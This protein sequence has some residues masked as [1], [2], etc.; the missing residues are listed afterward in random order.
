ME[1]IDL[2]AQYDTIKDKVN[3]RIQTV[4]DHRKFILGP[5]VEE[6]EKDM[7]K[8]LGVK[9]A[10]GVANGTD[11]LLICL[12]A[13]DVRQGDKVVVPAFTFFAT[14]EVVSML[15]AEPVFCDVDP[16]TY[17]LDPKALEKIISSKIKAIMPVSLYG[18][19]ADYDWINQIA[20][21]YKI[22]VIED[23]AQSFG[24]IYKGKRSGNLTTLAATSFFPAK[25]LGCYGDGGACF[26]NDD[27]LAER[28]KQLRFH[29]QVGRYNHVLVGHNSRL[30]TLQAA[31]LS[32][33]LSI[34]PKEMELRQ[35]VADA[36]NQGLKGK[37]KTPKVENFNQSA[38]AQYTIEVNNRDAFAK[39]MQDKGIPT[40][41]H[42]PK[43]LHL[44]PV[45]EGQFSKLKF[46]VSEAICQKVISLPMHPYLG[47]QDIQKIVSAV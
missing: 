32:E 27:K 26:T 15:G 33:K 41:V 4:L 12:R 19:C 6:F 21:Q 3:K 18:Q 17:N 46:P 29:G 25:P 35:K 45:Y 38:W 24:A 43:P 9:H 20:G 28:I 31:I 8:F 47:Q 22:P 40:A 2:G 34:F 42:Y 7:S 37:V 1:F 36:Y 11:A 39:K 5:E 30:D 23:A 16:D 10:I 44:Q 13:L 14:S